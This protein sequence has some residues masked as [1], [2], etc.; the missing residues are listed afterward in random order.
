[1]SQH[2]AC[3]ASKWHVNPGQ[4][5]AVGRDFIARFR[6]GSVP[7][8]E[9]IP[10]ALF[11]IYYGQ[12]SDDSDGPIEWCRPV[13]DADAAAGA[14]RFPELTLRTESAHE[15]AF[16]HLPI[17]AQVSETESMAVIQALEGWAAGKRRQPNGACGRS[18]FSP[19]PNLLAV[20]RPVISPSL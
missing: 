17:A 3:S 10:G 14:A 7:R 1:M 11:V 4:I 16:V 9:G 13:P 5:L 6:D 15:E 8:L 12:V 18:S 19:R 20:G 2:G